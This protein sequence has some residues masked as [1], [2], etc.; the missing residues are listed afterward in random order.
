M[1]EKSFSERLDNIERLLI[2]HAPELLHDAHPMLRLPHKELLIVLRQTK[3]KRISAR[4]ERL[5]KLFFGAAYS[6]K[7]ES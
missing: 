1:N 2:W 7:P 6:S 3:T 4:L 5:E